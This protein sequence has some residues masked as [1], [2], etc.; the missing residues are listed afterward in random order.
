[1]AA[2]AEDAII[3]SRLDPT[4]DEI[5]RY[6]ADVQNDISPPVAMAAIMSNRPVTSRRRSL[7]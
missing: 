3:F 7:C 6:L 4:E 1:M 2:A 5:A